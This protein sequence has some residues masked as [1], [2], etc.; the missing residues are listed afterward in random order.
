MNLGRVIMFALAFGATT[1][2]SA[3]AAGVNAYKVFA[4]VTLNGKPASEATV[5]V[6]YERYKGPYSR[7][8]ATDYAGSATLL[9]EE[10]SRRNCWIAFTRSKPALYSSTECFDAKEQPR[11]LH[12]EIR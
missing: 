8:A 11:T 4:R 7:T 6:K 12:L 5:E 1:Y 9:V 10:D 2:I 3:S